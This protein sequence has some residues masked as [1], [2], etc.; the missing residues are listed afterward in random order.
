MVLTID[1]LRFFFYIGPM[2][3]AVLA[4]GGV[5]SS[6]ALRLL[7]EEDKHELHAFYLKIW[8]EDELAS[9]GECPWE[10][11]L[12][13]V[14]ETCDRLDVP[15]TIV[16]LQGAYREKV[17]SHAVAE[18]KAGRTPSPDILCNERVKF[19]AFYD[20]IDDSFDKVAT[21]HYAQIEEKDDSFLL[22]RAPDPIKDQ[23]YF[24]SNLNQTQLRRALFPI[25]HLQ[26][27]EVRQLAADF[28][29]PAAKRK[30]SQGICFLG[31]IKFPDFVRFHLGEKT[32]DIVEIETDKVWG[33]HQGVW[34]YTIGQRQ[35]IGLHGGPWF[36]VD[37]NLETNTLYI[38]HKSSYME[39][40]RREF[41]VQE[42][43]WISDAPAS[44]HL[45]CKIRHGPDMFACSLK[46]LDDGRTQL[47][48]DQKDAGITPGQSAIFYEGD[49]CLGGGVIQ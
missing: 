8:L 22:K 49:Y 19:G 24:L 1:P 4:S 41:F 43:H 48:L 40:A 25:G 18:L 36:V 2:K 9:I 46:G 11:D 5:D 44:P 29:L 27:N 30:D 39:H 35:G 20:Q 15:L 14:R 16:P 10:E 47:T 34:F 38:S 7:K 32:G 3:I 21:G 17:V 33:Q 13:Y 6:L 12:T 28:E 23:T 31:K 37:K 26:K 42:P 45:H